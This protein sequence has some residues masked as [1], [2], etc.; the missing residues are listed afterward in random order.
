[1]LVLG[2]SLRSLLLSKYGHFLKAWRTLLDKAGAP[3]IPDLLVAPLPL[4]TAQ[5]SSNVC[6]W[7]E[8]QNVTST[9][10][11]TEGQTETREC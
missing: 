4:V 10:Q 8:F 3:V 11:Q 9:A 2:Y 1:M 6:N 5:D 7:D